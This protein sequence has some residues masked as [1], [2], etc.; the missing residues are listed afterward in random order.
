MIGSIAIEIS[1]LVCALEREGLSG[2]FSI[3]LPK[4]DFQRLEIAISKACHSEH[5]NG[6]SDVRIL[7]IKIE[8]QVNEPAET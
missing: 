7:G 3:Q 1:A 2:N 4:D 6:F 5:T 8:E